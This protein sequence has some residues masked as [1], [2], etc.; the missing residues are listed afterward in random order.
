MAPDVI[1]SYQGGTAL[2]FALTDAASGA[3]L[4]LFAHPTDLRILGTAS[5]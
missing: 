1:V 2:R 5:K 4:L 3:H